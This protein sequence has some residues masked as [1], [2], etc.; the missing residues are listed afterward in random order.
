MMSF[1]NSLAGKYSLIGAITLVLLI[2]IA[3]IE[4]KIDE[5]A[6]FQQQVKEEISNGWAGEQKIVGP[7]LIVPFLLEWDSVVRDKS[8]GRNVA[9]HNTEPGRVALAMESLELQGS[10]QSDLRY[11]GIYSVPVFT[12]ELRFSGT[13]NLR[14]VEQIKEQQHFSRFG[15]PYLVVGVT[16]Q[17]GFAN[18][19]E[20]ILNGNADPFLPGGMQGVTISNRSGIRVELPELLTEEAW[21]QLHRFEFLIKIRGTEI[22][23]IV[24]T[25][26]QAKVSLTG[27]WPH[28]KF[29]GQ[30]LPNQRSVE[31][32]G[33]Q[34]QW[35][36]SEIGTNIRRILQMCVANDTECQLLQDASMRMELIEPV[37]VYSKSKRALKYAILFIALSFAGF[38]LSELLSHVN[39][40]TVQ[41]IFVGL[42]IAMFY[43]LLLSLSEHLP[44]SMAYALST[45][46]CVSLLTSY[47]KYLLGS[48]RNGVISGATTAGFYAVLYVILHSEDYALLM[49]SL[50]L[51]IVLA[52][53]MFV[54]RDMR[55]LQLT[56]WADWGVSDETSGT[57]D[58]QV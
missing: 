35:Q 7:Y 13:M 6:G 55:E 24:P 28:P 56:S 29:I 26:R 43:L 38:I 14:E 54:T 2:P 22:L 25:A 12:A 58:Q 39:I 50:L 10:V 1:I 9:H 53:M 27:D 8:T 46:C 44:F 41:Y 23:S 37:N 51:L 16:D 40:H 11:R 47:G 15:E 57:A 3:M 30:Y 19:P 4:Q 18:Q 5:R 21:F 32:K 33:F 20:L 34:S 31:E 42:A 17:R 45:F 52:V 49:G 36:I 48:L